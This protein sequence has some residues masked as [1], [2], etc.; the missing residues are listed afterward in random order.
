ML[1]VIKGDG[2]TKVIHPNP[3]FFLPCNILKNGK[4]TNLSPFNK[5]MQ[6]ANDTF[7]TVTEV[8]LFNNNKLL[9]KF[10]KNKPVKKIFSFK[11]I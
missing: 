3:V 10:I 8:T 7:A 11:T 4:V 2:I 9:G 5:A 6:I 1:L